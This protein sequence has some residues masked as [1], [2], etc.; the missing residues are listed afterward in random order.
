MQHVQF[1]LTIVPTI[2]NAASTEQIGKRLKYSLINAI[3][4][5]F[6]FDQRTVLINFMQNY[7][8]AFCQLNETDSEDVQ[9]R[10][11]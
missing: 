1:V 8:S 10:V 7:C 2:H 5:I 3:M 4:A 9:K 6:S 11:F